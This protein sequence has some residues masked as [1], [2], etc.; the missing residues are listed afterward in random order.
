MIQLFW[1]F[2][3]H[4]HN[5][6][7][8]ILEG[9][10]STASLRN[11]EHWNLFQTV[12]D[13]PFSWTRGSFD[14]YAQMGGSGATLGLL[15]AIFIFS[16][17]NDVKTIAKLSAPMG[18]FNI[19]EP[20]IFGLP[21]VLNPLYMIPWLIVPPICVA[22]AYL[23]TTVGIIPPVF[24]QVPWVMPV[25]VYAFFATGGNILAAGVAILNLFI[26]FLI[27]TPFVLLANRMENKK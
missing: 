3:L 4:G 23:F 19:N 9:I 12:N 15:I 25:G 14:A 21:I 11:L 6:L 26:S 10:Y 8:P 2:G 17:R 5:V 1:F 7:A 27:W 18:V 22:V 24:V 13:M 16:K 20:I